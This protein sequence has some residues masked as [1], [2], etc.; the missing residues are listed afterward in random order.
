[1]TSTYL[2]VF[3]EHSTYILDLLLWNEA[4]A[5]LSEIS[6]QDSIRW[7]SLLPFYFWTWNIPKLLR[8]YITRI[9]MVAYY[10]HKSNT[11]VTSWQEVHHEH[12]IGCSLEICYR[13]NQI[14]IMI[15]LCSKYF[16][17]LFYALK[18]RWLFSMLSIVK[19]I[20]SKFVNTLGLEQSGSHFAD[21][22]FQLHPVM[23]IHVYVSTFQIKL[24][25][26][27]KLTSQ[28]WFR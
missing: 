9:H 6:Y 25:P 21:E 23:D 28:H 11:C 16:H 17:Y 27:I 5:Y 22:T 3:V 20:Q 15:M 14:D 12:I 4:N 10:N 18:S 8:S 2:H 19:A 24:F 26:W 13:Y 1:M 7:Y